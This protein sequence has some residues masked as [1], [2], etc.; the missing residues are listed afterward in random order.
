M[1]PLGVL[2]LLQDSDE[3]GNGLNGTED[4][5]CCLSLLEVRGQV[6]VTG[7]VHCFRVNVRLDRARGIVEGG[8]GWILCGYA[9]HCHVPRRFPS[10]VE[11]PRLEGL[12][13]SE[14]TYLDH[15]PP[16]PAVLENFEELGGEENH[17]EEIELVV[18]PELS[19]TIHFN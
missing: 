5:P 4:R 9:P 2:P 8:N 12:E 3:F 19:Q 16:L 1:F 15:T 11:A 18:G 7:L 17:G 6:R 13:C 14:G 10:T